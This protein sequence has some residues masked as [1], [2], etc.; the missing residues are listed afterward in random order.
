MLRYLPLLLLV[1]AVALP[2]SAAAPAKARPQSGIGLLLLRGDGK[3]LTIY[4]EPRLGRLAELTAPELPGLAPSMEASAGI[5]PVVVLS[6]RPGWLRIIYDMAESDGWVECRRAGDFLLWGEF[7]PERSISMLA[8]VRKEFH[9]LR[10]EAVSGAESL[11]SVGQ[12][13]IFRVVA[14]KGDW[15]RVRSTDDSEGWLRW[16][17]DNSRLLIA[18]RL[19][20][21]ASPSPGSMR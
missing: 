19:A 1:L 21:G 9:Q 2:E 12:G 6:K 20:D 18:V 15:I 7:L 10:R 11:R 4:R 5:Y 13:E 16:R 17:D 3:K 14:L 8:G